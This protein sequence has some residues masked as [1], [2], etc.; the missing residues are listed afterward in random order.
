MTSKKKT[1]KPAKPDM[2]LIDENAV[3]WLANGNRGISSNTLFEKITGMSCGRHDDH[4]DAPSDAWDLARCMRL[5]VV[6]PQFRPLIHRVRT[7]NRRWGI[8][9]ENW[10][11]LEA[12]LRVE[13]PA[14]FDA[15]NEKY[16]RDIEHPKAT[17]RVMRLLFDR[18]TANETFG[19]AA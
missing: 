3:R 11:I 1:A 19:L 4:L 10:D 8:V 15:A 12:I 5:V 16:D 17:Y 6:C 9:V 7:V 14:L 2:A 13:W 18:G